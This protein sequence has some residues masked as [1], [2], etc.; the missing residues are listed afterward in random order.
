MKICSTCGEEIDDDVWVCPFCEC[1]Q[2]TGVV[3]EVRRRGHVRTLNLEEGRPSV[4]EA[5]RT[6]ERQL[7]WLK[8]GGA[9]VVRVVHGWGSSGKGGRI[10]AACHE[11][12]AEK[13]HEKAIRG[14]VPG[15]SY[16][17]GTSAGRA[18]LSAY[19]ELRKSLREDRGNRGITFVEL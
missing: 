2:E 14:F 18:L 10:K 19:P 12:L 3:K 5:M 17:R 1:E 4:E 6:L 8:R 16:S 15:E 7:V 11:R 13:L 9:G